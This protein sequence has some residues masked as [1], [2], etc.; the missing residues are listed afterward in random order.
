MKNIPGVIIRPLKKFTDER[1]WL[2]ECFRQDEL[3][4]DLYPTMAYVSM[5]KPGVARGP[6]EH[7]EQTDYFCFCGPSTFKL[8]LWD[9]RPGSPSCGEKAEYTVGEDNPVIA[10]I[11]PKV[12]HA[13][14][15]V[16][17][18]DCFVINL[19]NRLFA[20]RNKRD[21][22]DEIRY[23]NQLDSKFRIED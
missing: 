17:K 8:Y 19:P 20:G 4:K 18:K 5:T 21:K 1:G 12:V 7:I 11:P 23:E 2:S 14:K 6:H 9:N 22:V 10:I 16:G 3:S 13:Y 15:N